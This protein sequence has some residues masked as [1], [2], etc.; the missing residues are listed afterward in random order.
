M[1]DRFTVYLQRAPTEN[2]QVDSFLG[3]FILQVATSHLSQISPRGFQT[4]FWK[5]ADS[6]RS[7]VSNKIKKNAD[8]D[9]S[10]KLY[11]TYSSFLQCITFN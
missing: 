11:A 5:M 4:V 9:V 3:I 1:R 6:S 10:L 2:K 8:D 7:S